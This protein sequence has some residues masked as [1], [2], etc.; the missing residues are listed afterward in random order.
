[1]TLFNT[2][3]VINLNFNTSTAQA[4]AYISVQFPVKEII[5]RQILTGNNDNTTAVQAQYSFAILYSDLVQNN[6]VGFLSMYANYENG[7]QNIRYYYKSPQT[8][9]G[10]YTFQLRDMT[11][12]AYS[13]TNA[14]T[15]YASVIIEFIEWKTEIENVVA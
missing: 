4:S 11:G 13:L 14:K 6:T 8:I 5:I 12:T 1:M 2:N 15:Y 9:N 10:L 3:R 7:L